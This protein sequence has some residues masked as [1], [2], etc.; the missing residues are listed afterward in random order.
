MGLPQQ[1]MEN[2]RSLPTSVMPLS[3]SLIHISRFA[4][5]QPCALELGATTPYRGVNPLDQAKYILSIRGAL[6]E[7]SL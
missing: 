1:D 6:T 7:N 2:F 5:Y 4:G 3:L